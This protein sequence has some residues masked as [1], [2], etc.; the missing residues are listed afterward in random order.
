MAPTRCPHAALGARTSCVPDHHVCPLMLVSC[1]CHACVV[2]LSYAHMTPIARVLPHAACPGACGSPCTEGTHAV[3]C[4]LCTCSYHA[5]HTHCLGP[6]VPPGS[7]A[8]SYLGPVCSGALMWREW[9]PHE[10]C[11]RRMTRAWLAQ[12]R[13]GIALAF[14]SPPRPSAPRCQPAHAVVRGDLH[15]SWACVLQL[16]DPRASLE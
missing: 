1:S 15:P 4:V 11:T 13:R 5:E 16:E 2:P 12:S 10:C 8:H 14:C 7:P 3:S 6:R 9:R